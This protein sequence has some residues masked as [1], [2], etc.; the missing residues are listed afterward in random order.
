M[1]TD[2]SP[3]SESV[4]VVEHETRMDIYFKGSKSLQKELGHWRG[5]LVMCCCEKGADLFDAS[6]H[7]NLVLTFRDDSPRVK[8]EREQDAA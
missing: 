5:K 2:F 7:I 8:I 4:A 1:I 3:E 6:C